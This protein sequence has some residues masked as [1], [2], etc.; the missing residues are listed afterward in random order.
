MCE[1]VRTREHVTVHTYGFTRR[2][3][4]CCPLTHHPLSTRCSQIVKEGGIQLACAVISSRCFFADT[5]VPQRGL[6]LLSHLTGDR[7]HRYAVAKAKVMPVIL[8]A[9]QRYQ[10]SALAGTCMEVLRNITCE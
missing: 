5:K 8:D 3:S 4:R 7:A 1:C 6:D 10:G 9:T 2:L